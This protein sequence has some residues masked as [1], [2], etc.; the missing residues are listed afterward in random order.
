MTTSFVDCFSELPDHRVLGRSAYPL[1][2]ILFL[3]ISAIVSGLDGWEAI[4]DFGHS[5]LTW[6]QQFFPYENGIPKHD[7]IARV[8]SAISPKALQTQFVKWVQSVSEITEGEVIAIDGKQARRSFDTRS[9]KSALH[10][11]SA[12]ASNNGIVLAQQKTDSKSNEITAIPK[13]LKLLEIK[14][15]I[16]TIDA[17]GCQKEIASA[18][19][20]KD[21]DYIL[22]LKGNQ[23]KLN[24]EVRD[25]FN[26]A[27]EED[28]KHIKK[29]E[30]LSINKGHGRVETRRCYAIELPNYMSDFKKDWDGLRS[31]VC[32]QST[33]D[34]GDKIEKENRYYISSLAPNAK[35]IA[36]AVRSH[37]GIEN[38]LHW[39]LDMTFKEDASRIRRGVAAE[40]MTVMRQIAIN[41]LKKDTTRNLSL[42]RKRRKALFY[43]DYRTKVVTGDEF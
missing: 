18:I 30:Y 5:K 24:D 25:F 4:E 10:M 27:L 28:F 6:L 15:C 38:S 34:L 9:R 8:I 21:A 26:V 3:S 13:L 16:V 12:W 20:A 19:R 33:R 37:W 23:G 11:V 7:T 22:A 14:G 1:I 43:D 31:L 39:V 35:Q 17:M 2:E 40:N 36:N 32:I 29:E 42:P 41:M